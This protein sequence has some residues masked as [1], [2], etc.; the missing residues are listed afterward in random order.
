MLFADSHHV[1]RI[2]WLS[3]EVGT[4]TLQAVILKLR[5]MKPA[6]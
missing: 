2:Q 5:H 3:D 6:L 1:G 4:F